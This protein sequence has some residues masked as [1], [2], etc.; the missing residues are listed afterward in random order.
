MES[1]DRLLVMKHTSP[2]PRQTLSQPAHLKAR[3]QEHHKYPSLHTGSKIP[4]LLCTSLGASSHSHTGA[5]PSSPS[6]QHLRHPTQPTA[7]QQLPT[8]HT[9]HTQQEVHT[10]HS[11]TD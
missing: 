4:G 2:N 11:G 5:H 8:Q 3:P 10:S 7:N 6:N 9:K 1:G